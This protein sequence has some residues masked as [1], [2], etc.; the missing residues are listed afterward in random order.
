MKDDLH[1]LMD[2]MFKEV[3]VKY[4]FGKSGLGKTYLA[5]QWLKELNATKFDIV[6][7]E[8]G[9]WIRTYGRIYKRFY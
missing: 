1:V 2:E 8:N 3:T 4:I 6:N 7:Y 5:S 9:F